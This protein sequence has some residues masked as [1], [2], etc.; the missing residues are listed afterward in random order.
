[1]HDSGK[2]EYSVSDFINI[3]DQGEQASP[4]PY[5]NEPDI[6]ENLPF[7]KDLTSEE[8]IKQ[9]EQANDG[10][11]QKEE[12]DSQE[13]IISQ[14]MSLKALNFIEFKDE[15]DGRKDIIDCS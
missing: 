7:S 12:R 13:T 1:M 8:L 11:I 5:D 2:F 10:L 6:D 4:D 15:Q 14:G 3:E 9:Q